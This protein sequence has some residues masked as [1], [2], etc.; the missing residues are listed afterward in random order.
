MHNWAYEHPA[1]IKEIS[2]RATG[3]AETHLSTPGLECYALRLLLAY[4]DKFVTGENLQDIFFKELK[5]YPSKKGDPH[6]V[7]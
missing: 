4:I 7:L 6:P 5:R 2:G 1:Q 3:F